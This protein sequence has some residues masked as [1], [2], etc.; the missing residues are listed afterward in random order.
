[1]THSSQ[2][3][4]SST[5]RKTIA[6]QRSSA[7]DNAGAL[8]DIH[9]TEWRM[10]KDAIS[11]RWYY[12]DP[13]SRKTRWDA[14]PRDNS[15]TKQFFKSMEANI[16]QRVANKSHDGKP[17]QADKP[18]HHT[19][20]VSTRRRLLLR[21]L[22]SIDD[23]GFAGYTRAAVNENIPSPIAEHK[24]LDTIS[25]PRGNRGRSNTTSTMY[26]PMGTMSSPDQLIT[27]QCVCTVLR[28]HLLESKGRT[29]DAKY[30]IF[31]QDN[32]S[33]R[34]EIP[35][36]SEMTTFMTTMYSRAQMETECVIMTLIYVERLLKAAN[37]GLYLLPTNWKT[38]LIS[39]MLMA[40][41]VWD[42][43]SMWNGDFSKICPIFTLQ[44]LNALE[45]A[46][47]ET[48]EYNVRVPASSYAKYYFHLRSLSSSLVL[49][50]STLYPL[51]LAGA[52]QLQVL[53][54]IYSSKIHRTARRV[55]RRG[56]SVSY[57]TQVPRP[58]CLE[59][60]VSME[61]RMAG[62]SLTNSMF[63]ISQETR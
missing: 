47:L 24:V 7:C 13:I 17:V 58:A 56:Q 40:S 23:T 19:V 61:T 59:Q 39:S 22:S 26:I 20:P 35:S 48:V 4:Q 49:P 14:P 10:A 16:Y 1:M 8:L 28:A 34:S 30:S 29:I 15:E 37:G 55:L 21:T 31:S 60:I 43:M 33:S 3:V 2:S 36:L 63:R 53:S 45:M 27:I 42:D 57:K 44:R 32:M 25:A 11:G 62:Q 12:Y 50:E 38:V 6:R 52:S 5:E 54:E 18:T 9:G 41:K 51:D 46:Y